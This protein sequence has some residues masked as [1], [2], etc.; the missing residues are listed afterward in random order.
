MRL[1]VILAVLAVV[2]LAAFAVLYFIIA[3]GSGDEPENGL[4]V[5]DQSPRIEQSAAE[6]PTQTA[7]ETSTPERQEEVSVPENAE[8]EESAILSGESAG[9]TQPDAPQAAPQDPFTVEL[10]D[11][12]EEFTQFANSLRSRFPNNPVSMYMTDMAARHSDELTRYNEQLLS[13][14]LTKEERIAKLKA[15]SFQIAEQVGEPEHDENDPAIATAMEE[16]ERLKLVTL[17]GLD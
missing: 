1:N 7:A 8:V 11:A 3:G 5:E 10:L 17:L 16:I 9:A 4:S 6:T 14:N 15:R 12:L 13:Q 2:V